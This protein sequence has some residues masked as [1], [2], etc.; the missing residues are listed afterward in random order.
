MRSNILVGISLS[1]QLR[2]TPFVLSSFLCSSSPPACLID[3]HPLLSRYLCSVFSFCQHSDLLNNECL[4]RTGEWTRHCAF[5][6]RWS[7]FRFVSLGSH[8]LLPSFSLSLNCSDDQLYDFSKLNAPALSR[9]KRLRI[10]SLLTA[11]QSTLPSIHFTFSFLLSVQAPVL[12]RFFLVS[13][14]L[15]SVYRSGSEWKKACSR[16]FRFRSARSATLHTRIALAFL[17]HLSFSSACL[18]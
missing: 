1:S 8:A 16:S 17:S 10:L 9:R 2:Q 11:I 6:R 18:T 13:C 14:V 7:R 3:S 5:G 12:T 4:K 15:V